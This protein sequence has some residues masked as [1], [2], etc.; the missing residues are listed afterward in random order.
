MGE[1]SAGDPC[2]GACDPGAFIGAV[3][4]PATWDL[5]IGGA[6]PAGQFTSNVSGALHN[7]NLYDLIGFHLARVTAVNPV[8]GNICG[9]QLIGNDGGALPCGDCKPFGYGTVF[10]NAKGFRGTSGEVAGGWSVGELVVVTAAGGTTSEPFTFLSVG[11][12]IGVKSV[13]DPSLGFDPLG[14]AAGELRC[15]TGQAMEKAFKDFEEALAARV[16][17]SGSASIIGHFGCRNGR[18]EFILD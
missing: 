14:L 7:Y 10:S 15:P 18:F 13:N 11:N 5:G 1:W 16:T 3:Y 8:N 9:A 17:P 2:A 12:A 4:A 6:F